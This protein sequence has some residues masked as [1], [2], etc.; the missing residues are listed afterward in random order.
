MNFREVLLSLKPFCQGQVCGPK[1]VGF[2]WV[3]DL[4]PRRAA[5]SSYD[6]RPFISNVLV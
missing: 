5:R 6:L 4:L 1:G 2:E 3:I